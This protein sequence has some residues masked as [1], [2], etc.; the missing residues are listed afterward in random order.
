MSF[1]VE[2]PLQDPADVRRRRFLVGSLAAGAMGLGGTVLSPGAR[3]AGKVDLVVQLGWVPGVNQ[4]GEIVADRLG[5]YDQEGLHIRLQPGGPNFDG[6]PVVASGRAQVGQVSS[7]PSVMFAVS[8]GLPIRCFAV[9]AQR[10][11]YC[12]FSLRRNPV[13]RPIDLVGRKVG[14]QPTGTALLRALLARHRIAEKVVEVVPIGTEFTP[15]LTGQV[16]VATG[17]LTN[18]RALKMLGAD[19]VDMPLWDAGVRLYALPYYAHTDLLRTAPHLLAAF[20]RATARGWHHART[21]REQAMDLLAQVLPAS[22]REDLRVG[23]DTMLAYSFGELASTQGWGAMDPDVW[24]DQI[25]LYTE[26]GLFTAPPP[27]L[28]D[29][30]TLDVLQATRDARRGA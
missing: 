22:D 2:S 13:R 1:E 20:L 21:H 6:V 10:H 4:A 7:S 9:G 5:F 28:S 19:R 15:L 26:L 29:V 24:Q 16:D 17:W 11:P 23:L 12:Y 27:K 14:V 3:A 30:I 18:T 25:A 8:Q